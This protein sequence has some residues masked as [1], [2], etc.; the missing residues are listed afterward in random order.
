[1][2]DD[3]IITDRNQQLHCKLDWS[4]QYKFTE[5]QIYLSETHIS[6]LFNQAKIT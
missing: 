6:A 1:M 4:F 3:S 2:L 5:F